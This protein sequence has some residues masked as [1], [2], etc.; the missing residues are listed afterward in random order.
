[1]KIYSS[2]MSPCK[3]MIYLIYFSYMVHY[4]A[5]VDHHV[6]DHQF[7]ASLYISFSLRT[8]SRVTVR[9]QNRPG[10]SE[11]QSVN[12]LTQ[13]SVEA[14]R[15]VLCGCFRKERFENEVYPQLE[16]GSSRSSSQAVDRQQLLKARNTLHSQT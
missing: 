2:P 12:H 5:C 8:P 11:Q 1:M 15:I 9:S 13:S 10:Q 6:V 4:V 3:Q 16:A 14:D 7:K